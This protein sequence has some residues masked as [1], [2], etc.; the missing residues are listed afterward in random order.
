MHFRPSYILN[1][2][3]NKFEDVFNVSLL[4]ARYRHF[5]CIET[6]LKNLP[7]GPG[8]DLMHSWLGMHMIWANFLLENALTVPNRVVAVKQQDGAILPLKQESLLL[9]LDCLYT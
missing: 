4:S 6:A 9:L 3:S 5:L 7:P 8:H 1:T 2:F